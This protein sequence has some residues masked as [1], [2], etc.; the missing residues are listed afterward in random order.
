MPGETHGARLPSP[1]KD[2]LGEID[3]ALLPGISCFSIFCRIPS[4]MATPDSSITLLKPSKVFLKVVV[5]GGSR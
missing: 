5:P 3:K 1:W 2:F 4:K